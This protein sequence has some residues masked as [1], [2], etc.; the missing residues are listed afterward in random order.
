MATNWSAVFVG[1][2]VMVVVDAFGGVVVP[3][4][5]TFGGGVIG[6]FVA[7]YLARGGF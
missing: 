1:F 7:G 5:G 2:L 3:V 4:V 6:G